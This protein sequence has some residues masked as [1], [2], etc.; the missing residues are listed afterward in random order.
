V[1]VDMKMPDMNGIEVTRAVKREHPLTEVILLTGHA[2]LEASAEGMK[3]GAFDYL[4]K[5]VS[6]DE[7]VYKIEDAHNNKA[8]QEAKISRL[9]KVAASADDTRG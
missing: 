6:I 5:P 2:S 1:V 4:L 3:S 7:L 8:L 9:H